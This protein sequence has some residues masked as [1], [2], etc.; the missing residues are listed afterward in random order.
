MLDTDPKSATLVPIINEINIHECFWYIALQANYFC[1]KDE[2]K[3]PGFRVKRKR[4]IK[5]TCQS[6]CSPSLPSNCLVKV[7]NKILILPRW[8]RE[9]RQKFY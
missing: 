8:S 9:K 1:Q 4:N 2:S 7:T 3:L 5:W 6:Y